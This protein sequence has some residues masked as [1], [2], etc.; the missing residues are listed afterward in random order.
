MLTLSRFL[1]RFVERALLVVGGGGLLRVGLPFFLTKDN[2]EVRVVRTVEGDDLAPARSVLDGTRTSAL[3][4]RGLVEVL[5]RSS[6][7]GCATKSRLAISTLAG[8]IDIRIFAVAPEVDGLLSPGLLNEAKVRSEV[9]ELIYV[10]VVYIDVCWPSQL[11]LGGIIGDG[12]DAH[13]G[14]DGVADGLGEL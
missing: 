6:H 4:L 11:D 1:K 13:V 8:N 9:G 3:E 5:P 10:W 12:W 14:R 2:M 7:K